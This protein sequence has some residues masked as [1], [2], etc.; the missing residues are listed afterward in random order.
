MGEQ[1][2]GHDRSLRR[3]ANLV[4]IGFALAGGFFLLAEHR[5]HIWGWF[6]ILLEIL[7]GV[8]AFYWFRYLGII[9]SRR[10]RQAT[11]RK[12]QIHDPQ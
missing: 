5:A 11:Q 12:E 4:L 2:K 1:R 6:P 10:P 8:L 7:V 9:P 3:R